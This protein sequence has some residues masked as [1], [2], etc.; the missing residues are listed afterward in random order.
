[1]GINSKDDEII[2]LLTKL[3]NANEGYPLD[4][5]E[6][7]RQG[8]L[9]HMAEMGLKAGTGAGIQQTVKNGTAAS[10][11]LA[12]SRLLEVAL[13]VA[14]V[15]EASVVAYLYRDKLADVFQSVSTTLQVQE[16]TAPPEIISVIPSLETT[17]VPTWTA[18]PT[19]T[20]TPSLVTSNTST[21]AVDN[22]N[23]S[24]ATEEDNDTTGN[25]V[26][27]TPDPRGN[28]GNHYGQTPKPELTRSRNN[29]SNFG[30][31]TRVPKNNHRP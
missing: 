28:N 1:M 21:G 23:N 11:P 20:S 9:K 24:A 18:T 10:V 12:T 27:S 17:G 29:D 3:K 4:M 16:V 15:A 30:G 13:V 6:T 8:Y 22:G 14:I 25:H 2:K 19:N 5:M 31:P 26:N 7:R